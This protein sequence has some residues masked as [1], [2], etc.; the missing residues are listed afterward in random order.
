MCKVDPIIKTGSHK[1]SSQGPPRLLFSDISPIDV[2]EHLTDKGEE[3]LLHRM[4]QIEDTVVCALL[5]W[6]LKAAFHR[7]RDPPLTGE[8]LPDSICLKWQSKDA[9]QWLLISDDGHTIQ[10]ELRSP[11]SVVRKEIIDP[12]EADREVYKLLMGLEL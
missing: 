8:Y 3:I 4:F 7:R 2:F 11:S 9:R 5:D 10:I 6:S 12:V 1:I